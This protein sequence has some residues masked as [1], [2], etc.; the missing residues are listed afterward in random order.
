L[1]TI[2]I[3]KCIVINNKIKL[4]SHL[5]LL[6]NCSQTVT[7]D[8]VT[9]VFPCVGG[10]KEFAP[11]KDASQTHVST[12]AQFFTPAYHIRSIT[13]FSTRPDPHVAGAGEPGSWADSHR[14]QQITKKLHFQIIISQFNHIFIR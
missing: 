12:D 3:V 5:Y 11:D 1:L 2:I 8:A 6:I 10:Y 7:P 4:F 13:N 9:W 14:S